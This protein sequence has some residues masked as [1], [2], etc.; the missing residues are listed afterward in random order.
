MSRFSKVLMLLAAGILASCTSS[1]NEGG[2]IA[3]SYFDL[4][5]LLKSELAQL[6]EEGASLEKVLITD[7]KEERLNIVPDSS[8]WHD[9]LK[10]FYEADINKPGF[11][12]EY[13]E[14]EMPAINDV[15]KVIYTSK[16][17]KH[18]V[19]VM[20]CF[21]QNGSLTEVRLLVKELNAIYN[22]TKELSLYFNESGITSF[23]IK[24]EES[25]RLKKDLNYQIQGT[26]VRA[27]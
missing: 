2:P 5:T 20:E 23:D 24:G 11:I 19:Q 25:M 6:I 8:G 3:N 10:L 17:R 13:F 14:E 4:G 1:K 27:L 15:S 22:V 7:G 26:I 21:Y 9:Q 16:S 12:G 18:P